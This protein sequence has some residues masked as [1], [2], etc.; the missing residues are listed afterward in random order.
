MWLLDNLRLHLWLILFLLD[1]TTASSSC[2]FTLNSTLIL[3][4]PQ[5]RV[6][7][8]KYTHY[9]VNPQYGWRFAPGFD[10][11]QDVQTVDR[12]GWLYYTA[13]YKGLEHHGVWYPQGVLEPI[14]SIPRDDYIFITQS[15]TVTRP[16]CLS[17]N[18][19]RMYF[20]P[21]M[22]LPKPGRIIVGKR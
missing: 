9:S 4:P 10:P 7:D 20:F 16:S 1:R 3:P 5:G 19:T 15:G 12:E 11:P 18:D 17:N 6:P 13:L 2:D 22:E 8:T 14:P 21:T